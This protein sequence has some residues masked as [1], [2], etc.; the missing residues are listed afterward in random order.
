MDKVALGSITNGFLN[1]EFV[2]LRFN[3]WQSDTISQN[4]LV[5]MGYDLKKIEKVEAFKVKGSYKADV[6]VQ[7]LVKLKNITDNQNLS[8]KL[9]SNLSGFNQIDK[10][11]VDKY[12]EMWK[13]DEELANIL[14][15]YS[16][17]LKPNKKTKDNRRMFFNEMSLAQQNMVIN[18][19]SNN[20]FLVASEILKGKGLFCVDWFL[21]IYA[22]DNNL[23]ALENINYV[24][25]YFLQGNVEITK[26]GNLKIGKITMQ[27][28]G[29]DGGRK[30][31]NMLQFK[32]NPALLI[33]K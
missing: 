29:G 21:V 28:K 32:I 4:W 3:N 18:F 33:K 12:K 5:K 17:E 20:K 27:R 1:E 31:A 13:F 23:W 10:R 9:V 6:Q 15:Q 16:G 26:S 25:N 8:I 30:T 22:K 2:V 24:I 11:Y 19:F 7:V 14:K